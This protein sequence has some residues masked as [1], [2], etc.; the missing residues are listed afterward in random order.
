MST[1][2][3]HDIT[4]PIETGFLTWPGDP[5][6]TLEPDATIAHNEINTSVISL[7]T[8]TG[9]HV[10]ATWHY[11]QDGQRLEEIP[12]A[13]WSGRCYVARIPDTI[14]IVTASDLEEVDIPGGVTHL[15]LKTRN[16]SFWDRPRPWSFDPAFVGI[17]A[18]AAGWIVD[19]G[20]QLV[21]IDYLG[22]APFDEPH[23]AT[24]VTLL[25]SDVLILEGLDLRA[26]EPGYYQLTCLPMRLLCGD[27]APAR[28]VLTSMP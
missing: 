9:T 5:D 13:R 1:P 24:H 18:A 14:D 12:I 6:V 27:G 11:L 2:R 16:S 22:I 19:R 3:V 26:V 20:I 4:L 17:D 10:D 8:H 23:H 15:L 7:G 21:G 25:G 28:A